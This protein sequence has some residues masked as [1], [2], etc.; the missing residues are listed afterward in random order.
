MKITDP[1][2][3]KSQPKVIFIIVKKTERMQA[4]QIKSY[5]IQVFDINSIDTLRLLKA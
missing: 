5:L 3:P 4:I 1:P 2:P